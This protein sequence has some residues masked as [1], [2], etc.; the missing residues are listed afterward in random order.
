MG[1]SNYISF[2]RR[3]I[4]LKFDNLA[5]AGFLLC[6]KSDAELDANELLNDLKD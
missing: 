4:A 1:M 5:D 6:L 2:K 3:N